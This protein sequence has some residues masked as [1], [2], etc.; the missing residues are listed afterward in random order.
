MVVR[1]FMSR[2]LDLLQGGL[3]GQPAMRFLDKK[4]L[5]ARG[6]SRRRG[7]GGH[8]EGHCKAHNAVIGHEIRSGVP[9]QQLTSQFSATVKY[10]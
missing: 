4:K 3:G 9:G 7:V 10:I 5:E 2:Q 1:R 8:S 6:S